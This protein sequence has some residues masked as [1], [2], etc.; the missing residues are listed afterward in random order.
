MNNA[1]VGKAKVNY[2]PIEGLADVPSYAHGA[3]GFAN[4]RFLAIHQFSNLIPFKQVLRD[5]SNH[6]DLYDPFAK[7]NRE[8]DDRNLVEFMSRV[9]G[10]NKEICA[11]WIYFDYVRSIEEGNV[12]LDV[13]A[14]ELVM[15]AYENA[16]ALTEGTI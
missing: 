12:N 1:D 16:L 6:V 11:S 13:T 15:E 9:T 8:I 10:H 2:V 5:R 7:E 14:N 3:L 4:Q